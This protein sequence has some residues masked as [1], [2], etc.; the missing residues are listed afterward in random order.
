MK[1]LF[2]VA[3]AL[4]GGHVISAFTI[5]R[6]M[7]RQGHYITFVGGEGRLKPAIEKEFRF[8]ELDIPFF[9]GTRQTYFTWE[10]FSTVAR[11]K[12]L[13]EKEKFNLIHAFDA[14]SYIHAHFAGLLAKTPVTCTLCGGIDPLYNIPLANQI[15]VFSEEQKAKM[16]N[17]FGWKPQQVKIIR[18]R[19][20]IRQITSDPSLP[21]KDILPEFKANGAG[22]TAMMISSFDDTKIRSIKNVLQTVALLLECGMRLNMIFIGGKGALFQEIKEKAEKLNKKYDGPCIYFTGPLL[23]AHRLL[24][25]ADIVLGVGRSAFEAMAHSIPTIIVGNNG[26]AGSVSSENIDDLAYYN[27]S[28]RNQKTPNSAAALAIEIVKLQ[29]DKEYYRKI[30]EVGRRFVEQEID[31]EQG[32]ERIEQVYSENLRP[33]PTTFIHRQ[34][35]SGLKILM[36][37][38]R[39][40]WW[41]TFGMPLKKAL[42]IVR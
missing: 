10:S 34:L 5:A 4:L 27:F 42:G 30:G 16:V 9:H 31:I 29:K 7:K 40:N 21:I 41:H 23:N 1:L 12:Q 24:T 6:G 32:V 13:I 26:M 19:L 33:K 3:S 2:I 38:W 14:R 15:M 18:T 35:I 11:L 8:I 20:D 22:P 17:V 39:D 25:H 28:G 37:I 36:P